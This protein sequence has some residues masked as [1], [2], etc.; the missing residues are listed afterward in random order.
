MIKYLGN[1]NVIRLYSRET[2]IENYYRDDVYRVQ[3]R[4][5]ACGIW[6][7]PGGGNGVSPSAFEKVCVFFFRS[8]TYVNYDWSAHPGLLCASTYNKLT[9]YGIKTENASPNAS[10]VCLSGQSRY[11]FYVYL[12]CHCEF[13]TEFHDDRP[14]E[15]GKTDVKS[16]TYFFSRPFF[17]YRRTYTYRK[18]KFWRGIDA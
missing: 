13:R 16:F 3:I 5:Y 7:T 10:L 14:R 2:L 1:T 11:Y 8:T 9:V 15:S 18:A 4:F 17:I 6:K 12:W